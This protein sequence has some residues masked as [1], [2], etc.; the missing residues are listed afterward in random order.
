M[1]VIQIFPSELTYIDTNQP[2]MYQSVLV[3]ATF[4]NEKEL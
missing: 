4:N 2:E 1:S 3:E